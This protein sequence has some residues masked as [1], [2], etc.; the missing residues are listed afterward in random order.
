MHQVTTAI[1]PCLRRRASS[2]DLAAERAIPPLDGPIGLG[3]V[4]SSRNRMTSRRLSSSSSDRTPP[5]PEKCFDRLKTD[6]SAETPDGTSVNLGLKRM[7]SILD[8]RD[9]E[10]IT[11]CSG[12]DHTIG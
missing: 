8:Q 6:G 10:S 12:L 11:S 7:G 9:P 3:T 5:R 4:N 1:H 2:A